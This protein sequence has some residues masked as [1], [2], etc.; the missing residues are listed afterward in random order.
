MPQRNPDAPD[1]RDEWMTPTPIVALA[2]DVLGEIDFDPCSTPAANLRVRAQ[3][4]FTKA[5]NAL[6]RAWPHDQ[7]IFM[8]PPYSRGVIDAFVSKLIDL[9]CAS[10]LRAAFVI[11]NNV[12]DTR[13]AHLLYEHCTALCYPQGRIHFLGP[14]GN[15][16]RQTRQGQCFWYFG[17]HKRLF[18]EVMESQGV[19]LE[20]ISSSRY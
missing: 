16:V 4:Y 7:R 3:R 11:T 2:R 12:T 5:D 9:A 1:D 18:R 8:N 15:P 17:E 13:W 14:D 10:R 20:R 19:V 6:V